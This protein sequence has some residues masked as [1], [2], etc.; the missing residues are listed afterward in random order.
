[1][2]EKM[3]TMVSEKMSSSM[4]EN[5]KEEFSF[6]VQEEARVDVLLAAYLDVSRSALKKRLISVSLNGSSVKLGVVARVGDFIEAALEE[7]EQSGVLKA[8]HI[9]LDIVFENN[10]V[11]VIN[12][13]FGMVVHPGAGNW[14]GTL[15]GALLARGIDADGFHPDRPGIVHRLDKDTSGVMITA[16]HATALEFLGRQFHDREVQKCYLALVHGTMPEERGLTKGSIGRNPRNRK[17]MAVVEDGSGRNAETAY[18]VIAEYQRLLGKI[19]LV[20]FFPKTGRTHQIR[21]H[22]KHIGHPIL[23]DPIYSHLSDVQ[24]QQGLMLHAYALE[25]GLPGFDEPQRFVAPLAER[26]KKLIAQWDPQ[27]VDSLDEL[28]ETRLSHRS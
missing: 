22:A 9:D 17:A 5:M 20:A 7:P 2:S 25:I 26:F 18:E 15:A 21:V 3:S 19:S 4:N 8:E 24:S 1:M 28:L 27:G 23:G 14:T 16:K 10:D 12:K 11:L 6:E 13:P